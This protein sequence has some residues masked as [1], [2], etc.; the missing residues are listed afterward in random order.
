MMS[1]INSRFMRYYF[2]KLGFLNI[3]F[4]PDLEIF[5]FVKDLEFLISEGVSTILGTG[6]RH[7]I[8]NLYIN[9]VCLSVCLFVSNKRQNG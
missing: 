9:L 4:Y 6:H 7:G 8:Q 3:G 5:I 1:G 2:S